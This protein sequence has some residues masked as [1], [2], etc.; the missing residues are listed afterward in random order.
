MLKCYLTGLN[1]ACISY[2]KIN[3]KFE[4]CSRLNVTNATGGSVQTNDIEL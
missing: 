2:G 3:Y 4:A 1:L